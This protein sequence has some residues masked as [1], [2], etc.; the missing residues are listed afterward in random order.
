MIFVGCKGSKKIIV[1]EE[2]LKIIIKAY[3]WSKIFCMTSPEPKWNF[4][5]VSET[6]SALCF[7]PGMNSIY[8]YSIFGPFITIQSIKSW[9]VL[10]LKYCWLLYKQRTWQ[11]LMHISV[12]YVQWANPHAHVCISVNKY[13]KQMNKILW[14]NTDS[15]NNTSLH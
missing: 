5:A 2:I 10:D 13:A 8:F 6:S 9:L 11:I 7:I 1:D 4:K 3:L 12:V 15:T 14:Q